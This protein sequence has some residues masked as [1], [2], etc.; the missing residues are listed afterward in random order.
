MLVGM[1]RLR[2]S[3][4]ISFIIPRETGLVQGSIAPSSRERDL[5]GTILSSSSTARSPKPWQ[6]GQA[7][8]GLLKEK[9]FGNGSS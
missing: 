5:S 9:R 1:R 6:S 4:S 7:P 3:R 2:A 8:W